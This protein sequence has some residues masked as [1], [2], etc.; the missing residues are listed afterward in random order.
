MGKNSLYD[1]W[2]NM[3]QRCHNP[4]NPDYKDYGDRGIKVCDYWFYSFRNFEYWCLLNGYVPELT[5]DRKDPNGDYEPTNCRWVD[6]KVQ[7][8][9]KRNIKLYKY[10]NKRLS[11]AEI[12]RIEKLSKSKIWHRM[13]RQNMTLREALSIGNNRSKNKTRTNTLKYR[14]EKMGI[15]YNAVKIRKSRFKLSEKEAIRF[16]IK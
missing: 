10:K 1:R 5:L 7:A 14:C 4:N 3:K 16:Y 13:Y 11:L 8:T 2:V 15:N 12:C 6:A 9:N